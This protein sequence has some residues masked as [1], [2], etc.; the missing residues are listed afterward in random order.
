MTGKPKAISK[1]QVC[2]PSIHKATSPTRYLTN[3]DKTKPFKDYNP[4]DDESKRVDHLHTISRIGSPPVSPRELKIL[5]KDF[6][7]ETGRLP[8]VI[9]CPNGKENRTLAVSL[10]EFGAVEVRFIQS[11]EFKVY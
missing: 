9:E 8:T 11:D 10:P 1:A 6:H 5:I 2:I 7:R 3:K 4:V